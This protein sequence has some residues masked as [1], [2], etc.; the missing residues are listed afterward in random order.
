MAEANER[1]RDA[2]N[3]GTRF[4]GRVA[5]V[6]HVA[7]YRF[8]GGDQR[9]RTRGRHAEMMHRLA[10]QKFADRRAQHSAAVGAARIR[11]RPGALELQ[12]EAPAVNVDRLAEEDRAAIAE[13]IGPVAE[14]MAAVAGG[15]SAHSRQQGVAGE[16]RQPRATSRALRR[17]GQARAPFRPNRRAAAARRPA[18]VAPAT[19]VRQ[20]PGAAGCAYRRRRAV[21]APGGCQS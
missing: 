20:T 15:V 14:L 10:A 21:R 8:A 6:E 19:T 16:R 7:P 3:D 11:R 4:V 9:Q 1:R 5:V 2:A 12:F 13:L 18:S 17:R